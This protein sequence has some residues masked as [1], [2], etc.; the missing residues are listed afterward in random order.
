VLSGGEPF[1]LADLGDDQHRGVVA[2]PADLAQQL[3]ALVGFGALVDLAG[4]GGDL[5]VEVTDQR[6]QTVKP[7][8]GAV[9]QRQGGEV[10]AASGAEQVGVLG[11]D[12]LSGHQRVHPVS[13]IPRMSRGL[14]QRLCNCDAACH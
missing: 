6:E 5:A 7:A 8:A 1:G 9:W 4:G 14:A 10:V 3:D 12:P 13:G 2:D 11:Q